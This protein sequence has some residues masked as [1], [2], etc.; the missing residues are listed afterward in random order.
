M[1]NQQSLESFHQP[2]IAMSGTPSQVLPSSN[3]PFR[4]FPLFSPSAPHA[5]HCL[6]KNATP[7]ASHWRLMPSTHAGLI[8]RA[9]RPD[10]P[11]T[12]THRIPERSN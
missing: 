4:F 9:F 12:I 7:A 2:N 3:L 8:G 11:P 6:K 1:V 5:P 10:S